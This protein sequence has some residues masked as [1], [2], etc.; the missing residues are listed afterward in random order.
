MMEDEANLE[1]ALN[2]APSEMRSD[3]PTMARIIGLGGLGLTVLGCAAMIANQYG[4]RFVGTTGGFL[5]AFLGILALLFHAFRDGDIEFRRLYTFAGMIILALAIIGS[6]I[7]GK[8]ESET[9][10]RQMAYYF[11]P[12]GPLAATIALLFL[13]ASGRH[14]TA[15][16]MTKTVNLLLLAVGSLLTASS[17]VLGV[18]KPDTLAGPGLLVALVGLAYLCSYLSRA[19]TMDG[20]GRFVGVSLG[21]LGGFSLFYAVARSLFPTILYDGPR[22]LKTATQSYDPILLGGRLFLIALFSA[23]A[24]VCARRWNTLFF[25]RVFVSLALGLIA[26]V[27]AIGTVTAPLKEP[28]NPF[29]VPGGLILG[30]LGTVY[31]AFSLAYCSDSPFVALVGREMASFFVSPIAYLVLIGVSIISIYGYGILLIPFVEQP[32]IPQLEPIVGNYWAASMGGAFLVVVIVPAITMRLFS[33]E[34]RTGSLEVL[35]TAPISEWSVLGSKFLAAWFFY[36]ITWVPLGLY[37][38]GLRAAGNAFDYRPMLSYYL[39]QAACG[40]GFISMGVFFS[41]L[42]RNQIIAAVLSFTGCFVLLLTIVIKSLP[43]GELWAPVKAVSA[44]LDYM[45][46]WQSA[47]NGQLSYS[48]V[49][50]YLSMMVF[51]LFATAKVLESRRWS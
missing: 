17:I 6:I 2:A 12:W 51:W 30:L 14:E 28:L 23:A 45:T 24:Y 29:L 20:M 27:L 39:V 37:L 3:E 34:K 35:L 33:E 48:F 49:V 7:P 31:L 18:I 38:V 44:R 13:I 5:F 10:A 47:L 22:V 41:C 11:L 9:V 19:G 46:A 26:L 32:G 25:T 42:T 8:P 15:A 50:A 1:A 21:I 16:G 43:L 40:A 4:P 36:M